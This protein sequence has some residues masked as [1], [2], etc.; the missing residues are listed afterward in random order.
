M[1]PA[2]PSMV[3]LEAP[4]PMMVVFCEIFSSPRPLRVMAVPVLLTSNWM[5]LP[6]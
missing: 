4:G 2:L 5:V 1:L 3:R 6:T